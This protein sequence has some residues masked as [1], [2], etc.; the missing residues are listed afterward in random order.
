MHFLG[1]RGGFSG[2]RLWR[3]STMAGDFCLK[4]WPEGA[5][6]PPRLAWIH[7]LLNL[8]QA[9]DLGFLPRVVPGLDGATCIEDDHRLWDMTTWL[10]GEASF[11]QEP[12]IA[13][14]ASA[15]TALA[16]LHRAWSNGGTRLGPCPVIGRRLDALDNFERLRAGSWRPEPLG[17]DPLRPSVHAAWRLLEEAVPRALQRLRGWIS[18]NLP[19]HPC[20]C[21]PWHDNLLFTGDR[22][23][24]LVDH[25]SVKVDHAAVDLARLLGSL[26][27]DSPQMWNLGL[28]AYESVRPLTEEERALV[29]LLDETG[30]VV[31]ASNWLRWL[32]HEGRRYDSTANVSGRLRD[33]VARLEYHR[34]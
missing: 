1:N 34:V 8:A 3:V 25:G 29:P 27:G 2:A 17:D 14:L 15:C 16:E 7:R 22:L 33:I 19:L 32:Y 26:V 20:W 9:A 18:R 23:T 13:R 21:D 6:T 11:H 12:T 4:A 24:G 10:S 31:A 30:V 28:A 5:M